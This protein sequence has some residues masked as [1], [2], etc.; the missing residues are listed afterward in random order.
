M[1][2]LLRTLL[3]SPAGQK[4][5]KNLGSF[6][7]LVLALGSV[8]FYIGKLDTASWTELAMVLTG[9]HAAVE[10]TSIVKTGAKPGEGGTMPIAKGAKK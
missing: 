10:G 7:L 4:V 2:T 9:L 8:F 6:K 3:M 5:V 1:I